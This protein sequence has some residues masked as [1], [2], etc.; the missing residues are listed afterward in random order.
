MSPGLED[1]AAFTLTATGAYEE[2]AA[3]AGKWGVE[4]DDSTLPVLAQ[5]LGARAEQQQQRLETVAQEQTRARAAS[6]LAVF[7]L[8]GNPPPCVPHPD[9]VFTAR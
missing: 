6:E 3:V 5:R 4:V 9:R 1:K 7:M 8:E 2:A